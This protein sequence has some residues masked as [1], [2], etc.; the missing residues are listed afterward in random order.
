MNI[1]HAT[2][3]ERTR[4]VGIRRAIGAT[5]R[6]ILLQFMT[7]SVLL[8]FIG[9]LVGLLLSAGIVALVRI[10]FPVALNL[11]AVVIAFG[12]SSAIGIF[13]GVF[14]AKKAAELSPIEAIR[15]E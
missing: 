14:P 4:E 9:G 10:W 8:S 6:D 7:E 15:Y 13:F 12:V 5:K 2:V 11:T 1:M 3:T